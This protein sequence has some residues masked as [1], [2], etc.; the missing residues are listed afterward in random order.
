MALTVKDILELDSLKGIKLITGKGGIS[1]T[2][3][4]AGIADFEFS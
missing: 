3:T 1:N 2:V 4:S